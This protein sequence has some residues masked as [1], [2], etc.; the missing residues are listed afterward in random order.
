MLLAARDTTPRAAVVFSGAAGSWSGSPALKARLLAAVGRT[1][2]PVFLI[3]AA[4][5]YSTAPGRALADEMERLGKPH[6]LKIYAAAGR[7]AAEGHGFVYRNVATWEP[8]VFAFL[9]R[10][11][12]P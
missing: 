1:A 8:D 7:S 2:A 11:L 6:R 5:D 12:R 10:R 4:N 3:Q 9:N